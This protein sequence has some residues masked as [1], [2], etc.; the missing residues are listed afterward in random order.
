MPFEAG[1]G[2]V[3]LVLCAKSKANSLATHSTSASYSTS[4][5]SYKFRNGTY[6]LKESQAAMR[7]SDDMLEKVSPCTD[8]M[9]M[10]SSLKDI[11]EVLI[12][13]HRHHF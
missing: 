8:T 6:N 2:V 3:L 1:D 10:L 5:L 11:L 4:V 13:P 12:T 9:T 7:K